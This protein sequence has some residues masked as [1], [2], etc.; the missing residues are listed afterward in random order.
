MYLKI[1]SMK[2][3]I[4]LSFLVGVIF[5]AC[6]KKADHEKN[7]FN[8]SEKAALKEN[9]SSEGLSANLNRG[10]KR[11]RRR[12]GLPCNCYRCFGICFAVADD[13][14]DMNVIMEQIGPR[15]AKLYILSV[16]DDDVLTDPILYVD[17]TVFIKNGIRFKMIQ[18]GQYAYSNSSGSVDYKGKSYFY[19]GTVNVNY[20]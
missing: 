15:Q 10:P 5:V 2:N 19:Y 12:D 17:D 14:D 1:N 11:K 3:L 8:R 7:D 9:M 13:G 16:P 4:I 20:E 18:S 6:S